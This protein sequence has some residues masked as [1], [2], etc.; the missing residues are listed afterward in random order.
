MAPKQLGRLRAAVP[1]WLEDAQNG[2][3]SGFRSLLHGLWND[4]QALDRRVV[5]LD[6]E[7]E[8]IAESRPDAK[9]LQPLR[10]VGPI[11]ATARITAV[12]TADHFARG[13]QLAASLG[14]TPK[15]HSTGGKER[16]L[17]ITKR[18]DADLRSL[19][20]H[21]ARALIHQAQHRE[22]RL[23]Q[24]VKRFNHRQVIQSI[25]LSFAFSLASWGLTGGS[26]WADGATDP[27]LKVAFIGDSGAGRDFRKVL[28]LIKDQGADLVLHQGDLGYERSSTT[29]FMNAVND[30]LGPSFPYFASRG[31]HDL[32]WKKSYQPI[33]AQRAE[34]VGAVCRGDY[35]QNSAC[36]YRGL[37]FILS[38][39]GEKG[40]R[41]K[42]TRYIKGELAGDNSIWRICSWHRN[43][44]S[45]QVGGKDDEVGWGPYEACRKGGAIIATAHEHSYSR[46]RTL[47]S[48]KK[49]TVDPG[50]DTPAGDNVCVT[51]KDRAA[52]R[53]GSTFVFV[54][55]LGGRRTRHQVGSGPI[56]ASIYTSSQGA[57]HGA[58][59]ITF[60]VGGDPNKAKG[61]F[62][63]TDGE[64]IDSFTVTATSGGA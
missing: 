34:A 27:N 29:N 59:F 18:G 61:E 35:G 47:T 9:R 6:R 50:C 31:N 7:I 30:V 32:G 51:R 38:A 17:G 10:A 21:G 14:L 40:S 25:L 64:V 48:T 20:V 63:N 8:L 56:W 22:D 24:W 11:T 4:R 16:L 58:L 41:K 1:Q 19:W 12:G 37:F 55:G 54:S 23:S 5:E 39:G 42:N 36:K 3:T 60:N 46:T 15:Q 26:V 33:L 49:Q 13:R 53:P 62:V 2:L 28:R 57:K 45:M 44:G 43:Q 52:G